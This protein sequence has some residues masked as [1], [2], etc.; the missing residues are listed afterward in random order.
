MKK[1]LNC[2]KEIKPSN[3]YCSVKCQ[4]E[5]QQK[6]WEE[7]WLAGEVDGNKDT[8]WTQPSCRVRTYL[9]KKYNNKC[10][11]CGWGEINPFT[12]TIPLEI[13]HIDGNPYNTTPENVTLLC[14]NCHSLTETY[15]GANRGNGRA[16]TW[17]P[18]ATQVN[19]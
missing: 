8:V 10:S 4:Q 17:I 13:E 5:Y 7:K 19:T 12:G 15:R 18:K 11:K 14:P 16:K 1:C 2:E 3:K 6:I 9:L